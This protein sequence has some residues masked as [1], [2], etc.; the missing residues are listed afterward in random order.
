MRTPINMLSGVLGLIAAVGCAHGQPATRSNAAPQAFECAAGGVT[1]A[2]AFGQALKPALDV[3]YIEVISHGGG[4]EAVVVAERGAKCSAATN[5][6]AC[7]AELSRLKQ[8]WVQAQ[9]SCEDCRGAT[10]VL[11]TRG[12]EVAKRTRPNEIMALLGAIDSP[13]D[14]WLLL[15]ARDGGPPYTCGDPSASAYR[16]LPDSTELSRQEWTSTC[17]PVERVEIVESF[18]RDGTAKTLRRTVV[19]HEVDE[20]FVP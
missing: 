8:A 13:A 9:P 3:D 4:H 19:E 14:A 16:V 7:E 18:D 20:C 15:M 6:A 5:T 2:Q 1:E 12:D 11:T 17:R 10:L